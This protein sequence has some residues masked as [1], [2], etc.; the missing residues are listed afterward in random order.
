VTVSVHSYRHQ[1]ALSFAS[2]I[3]SVGGLLFQRWADFPVIAGD[4]HLR[5]SDPFREHHRGRPVDRVAAHTIERRTMLGRQALSALSRFSF[6][7]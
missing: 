4:F 2:Q 7:R 3:V 1:P 5:R 6:H